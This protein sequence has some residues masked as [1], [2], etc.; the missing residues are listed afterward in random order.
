[1]KSWLWNGPGH[2][3]EGGEIDGEAE[4]VVREPELRGDRERATA[5][6]VIIIHINGFI[7]FWPSPGM[8]RG[9]I[10]PP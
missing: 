3:A 10:V 5:Y 8:S 9:G 4:R 2:Q 7:A 6:R 1:M